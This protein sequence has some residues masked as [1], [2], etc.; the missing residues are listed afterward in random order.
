M[1]VAAIYARMSSPKQSALSPADQ[2]TACR[3]FAQARGWRAPEDLVFVDT[4]LSGESRFNRLA[5]LEMVARID[6]WDVLLAYDASRLGQNSE[7]LGWLRNKLRLH[8]RTGYEVASG[9]DL[10]NVGAKVMGVLAE[11]HQAKLRGDTQRGLAGRV[12]RGM[13]AGETPYGYRTV[14][15]PSGRLGPHGQSIA[16]G[17]RLEVDPETAAVVGRIFDLYAAGGGASAH[18]GAAER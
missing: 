17:Y 14:P 2:V 13:F 8:R 4:E 1:S 9:L 7:D 3:R 18:R 11:E 5:S 12:E 16:E 15:I 10:F 6:E